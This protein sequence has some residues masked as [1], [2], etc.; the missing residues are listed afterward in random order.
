[1]SGFFGI[2]RPQA[3]PVDLEAFEQMKTAMHREGFDGMETHV[4]EKIAI[5]HLM[6]RVSPESKYDTQ[7][8]KSSCG[9]YLLVGHFRLDY[10]D[11]LG[12]RLGLTQSELEI[13]PDSQLVMLAYQKWNEKCVYYFEGD[14]SFVIINILS[15]TFFLFKD[16]SGVSSLYFF[17]QEDL[18]VFSDEIIGIEAYFSGNLIIEK[19]QFARIICKD[20]RVENGFTLFENIFQVMAGAIVTLRQNKIVQDICLIHNKGN[21]VP[22]FNSIVDYKL[23][24]E[25]IFQMA[26]N[27][28]YKNSYYNGIYLSSGHD[29]STVMYYLAKELE[30]KNKEL[31]AFTSKPQYLH[32][33]KTIDH[34]KIDE[35]ILVK[36][37]VAQFSNIN[38]K[39]FTCNNFEFS[40]MI[41]KRDSYQYQ[42][43]II[44]VN[45][46]WI[47][48]I[49]QFANRVQTKSMFTGQRGNLS[50]SVIPFNYFLELLLNFNF[51]T[52]LRDFRNLK[53]QSGKSY[54][55]LIGGHLKNPILL[56]FRWYFTRNKNF[57]WLTPIFN[58]PW[59]VKI[60]KDFIGNGRLKNDLFI[61]GNTYILNSQ[62]FRKILFDYYNL[63]S[64]T[65]WWYVSK[66]NAIHILDPTSDYRV[67]NFSLNIPEKLFFTEGVPKFLFKEMM[68]QKPEYSSII[69]NV[70]IP[71]SI[72]L[73]F[74]I[75]SD[76]SIKNL[77][78]SL[79]NEKFRDFDFV[80]F[81]ELKLKELI[82]ENNL[83]KKFL[84][85][86]SFLEKLSLALFVLKNPYICKEFK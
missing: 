57:K 44:P 32:K 78:N 79:K 42:N 56:L 26:V 18:L 37:Y 7:P 33:I 21:V 46:F 67:I 9:N 76:E 12:D 51:L 10:R 66:R 68:R 84:M 80:S 40:N 53:I 50:L 16:I 59:M 39:E 62:K 4:E 29:S 75:E 49:A 47:E 85:S 45:Q 71:Q 48:E 6:L 70:K 30:L 35:T 11:E 73:G 43:P 5:G 13:T 27:T 25:S 22:K 72:D 86:I 15:S 60:V 58:F 36:K 82:N 3:G 34:I 74:R 23:E 28:R 38:L 1:M 41:D 8:L 77:I 19:K 20:L 31:N 69:D 63:F 55:F 61:N 2:F 14:W 83:Q 81:F 17:A 54:R 52:F 24:F 64:S 65:A